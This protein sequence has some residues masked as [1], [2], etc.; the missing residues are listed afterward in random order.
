MGEKQPIRTL[1][2]LGP[3]AKFRYYE[4]VAE[5]DDGAHPADCGDDRAESRADHAV[6]Q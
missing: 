6:K 3:D 5:E 2:A 4:T 1:F